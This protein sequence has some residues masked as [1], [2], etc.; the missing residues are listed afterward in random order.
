VLDELRKVREGACSSEET[1]KEVISKLE[2]ELASKL[3][4]TVDLYE[5]KVASLEETARVAKAGRS[6]A[7]ERR[8]LE[9]QG[10]ATDVGHLKR[11]VRDLEGALHGVPPTLLEKYRRGVKLAVL[12][13][14][15]E[16]RRAEAQHMEQERRSLWGTG[17]VAGS[18]E[19]DVTALLD[20]RE[21]RPRA[22]SSDAAAPESPQADTGSDDAAPAASRSAAKRPSDSDA[23]ADGALADAVRALRYKVR[24]LRDEVS[25]FSP[26]KQPYQD[27]A[28]EPHQYEQYEYHYDY[29]DR[30]A[31]DLGDVRLFHDPPAGGGTNEEHFYGHYE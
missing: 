25:S 11:Q 9:V 2:G 3:R 5:T 18:R 26:Q 28:A 6:E 10:F 24:G 8:R 7:L 31:A 14:E 20:G 4:R 19:P 30:H 23:R 21:Q 22:P 12:R 13:A 27:E 29:D 1:S 16:E 17:V 15:R